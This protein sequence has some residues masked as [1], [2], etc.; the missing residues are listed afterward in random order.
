MKRFL[1]LAFCLFLFAVRLRA[2]EPPKT[3]LPQVELDPLASGLSSITSI[4]NAGD[5]RLFLTL[6]AGQ[7]VIWDGTQTLP[8]P[9]LD[10]SSL[11][12]VS[13]E[14][15]LLSA[16]FHPL[17]A[18][19]GIFFVNYTDAANG[20]TVV[21]RYH[22]STGDPN[23][24]DPA[25]AA[26]LLTILQPF[27][28]HNGGQL[29]FG[30]DG[31]LYIGMGDGGSGNDPNCNAQSDDSRLGKLL[32]IDVDRN[33]SAPPFYAIPPDNPFLSSGGPAEAWAK[34]LRNPWR[35]SFD[36]LTGD[37]YIGDV[38]QSA[39]E[40]IDYQ[41]AGSP[42]GQNYGWKVMEGTLCGTEGSNGCNPEPPACHDPAYTLPVLEYSH[43]DGNCSVTGGYLVRG[44][45]VPLLYGMYVYGDYC[46]GQIHMALPQSGTW[47]PVDLPV[48]LPSLTTFGEDSAGDLYAATSGGSLYRFAP[49][50]PPA[51][52]VTTI[53]PAS[54]LTR[55]GTVVTI[56]GGNFTA[57]TTVAFGSALASVHV[58]NPSTLTA[59]SPPRDAGAVDVTVSNPGA[60]PVTVPAAFTYVPIDRVPFRASPRIT[61]RD[62]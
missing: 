58:L 44:L 20:S 40:E 24:A 27:N 26:I 7:V 18:Q 32:R 57:S 9:F 54:G 12:S 8:A 6:Q 46:S 1:T 39:R 3:P 10:V 47:S 23:R 25:S 33:D 42:G 13:G 34:G 38:G 29:Q 11:I 45:S 59:V 43:D 15:G 36:R 19:N 55:G 14:R 52:A 16:A 56:T 53:G 17:Y 60:T 30:P 37:L 48:S 21:A 41:P 62:N 22:V 2:G 35:F 5:T 50:F 61:A 31:Y 4:T 51:P 49:T 28:N